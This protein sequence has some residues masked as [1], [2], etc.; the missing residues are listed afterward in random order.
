MTANRAQRRAMKATAQAAATL[1]AAHCY[2]F[3]GGGNLVRIDAPHAVAALTRAFVL[4]LRCG[5]KPVVVPIAKA[6]AQG[7]PRWSDALAPDGVTWLAVGMD[8][9]G[10]ASYALQTASSPFN[11]F[12]HE[13]AREMAL[14]NLAHV[15]ATAGFP[16]GEAEERA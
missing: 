13:A 2:D 11:P 15:C 12:A 3:E 7:F 9:E 1:M 10:R 4:L 8:R 6:E 16:M 14:Q 5:G